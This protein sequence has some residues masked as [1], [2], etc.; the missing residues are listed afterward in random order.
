[1]SNYHKIKA[2]IENKHKYTEVV[3]GI[4]EGV[5]SIFR[6]NVVKIKSVVDAI[7]IM[8]LKPDKNTIKIKNIPVDTSLSITGKLNR[9]DIKIKNDFIANVIMMAFLKPSK[10]KVVNSIVSYLLFVLR[11][12]GIIEV[13]NSLEH[14]LNIPLNTES[15]VVSVENDDINANLNIE[16]QPEEQVVSIDNPIV[17]AEAWFFTRLEAMSGSLNAYYNQTIENTGRKKVV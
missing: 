5:L 13:Q 14:T 15:T 1:M 16:L 8:L 4:T 9:S 3:H 10:I 2:F 12:N 17:N 11:G 7:V 6:R